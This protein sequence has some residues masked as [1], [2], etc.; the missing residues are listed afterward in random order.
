MLS[1]E[2]KRKIRESVFN[3][4]KK[5]AGIICPRIGKNEKEILNELEQR[6]GYKII[7][8]FKCEGYFIDGYI[9]ETNLAIEIDERPK[10]TEKDLRREKIIKAQL[11]CELLRI[12]DYD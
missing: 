4:A 3:Y 10:N 12:K 11:G 1:E 9:T 7:R 8:Q 2:H 5:M 6:L